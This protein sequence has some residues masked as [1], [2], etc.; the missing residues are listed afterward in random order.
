MSRLKNR[1]L[2]WLYTRF[3]SL[4]ERAVRRVPPTKGIED[5]PWTPFTKALRE[6]KVGLVTTAG[7]HL[8]DQPPFDMDDPLGDPSF[9]ILPRNTPREMF[10]ITHD[11]YDHRDADRDVNIVFPIDRLEEL[12]EEGFIGDVG[13]THYGFMG[14]IEGEYISTLVNR[15]APEVAEGFKAQGVDCVVLTPG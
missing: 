10:T 12:R 15:Y 9:R 7:V 3:P 5:I 2:A 4:L 14:H 11:Y 13:D 1:I 8:R 6:A